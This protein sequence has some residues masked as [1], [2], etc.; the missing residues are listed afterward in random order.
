M[1]FVIFLSQAYLYKQESYTMLKKKWLLKE[2]DKERVLE[3]SKK[4]KISPLTAIILYNRGIRNDGEIEK[5]LS[6]D[7]S[8]MYDPFLMCD[9]DK[10]VER[11]LSAKNGGE[12]I[13]IYGDYDVDGITAIA[14]LYKHLSE[15]VITCFCIE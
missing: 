10:A 14:I 6:R 5:F 15:S 1:A 4:F 13:T 3:I 9:M 7:L 11:I 12:K 2:F 8:V